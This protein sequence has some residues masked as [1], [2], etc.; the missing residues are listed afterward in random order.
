MD[1][2][3]IFLNVKEHDCLIVGG[4]QIAARKIALLRKAGASITVIAPALCEELKLLAISD[5]I[6]HLQQEFVETDITRQSVIIAATNKREVNE[7]VSV[8]AQ[9]KGIRIN[10]R[11][12]RLYQ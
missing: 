3:P 7:A 1:F 11:L 10:V 8:A 6:K 2:L 5:D 9:N 4:G 12:M